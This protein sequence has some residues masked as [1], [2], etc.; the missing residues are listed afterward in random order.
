L[1]HITRGCCHQLAVTTKLFQIE[2][3]RNL[4][5]SRDAPSVSLKEDF[6]LEKA[7]KKKTGRIRRQLGCQI[8]LGTTY[9]NGKNDQITTNY[10]KLPQNIPHFH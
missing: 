3:S 8:L 10:T 6:I 7:K 5:F 1:N 2:F 9:Q 4:F